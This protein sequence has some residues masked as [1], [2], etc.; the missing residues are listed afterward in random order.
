MCNIPFILTLTSFEASLN[1][2]I[3]VGLSHSKCAF[4]L[5]NIFQGQYNL[6][7]CFWSNYLLEVC[8]LFHIGLKHSSH[9]H[10]YQSPVTDEVD[11]PGQIP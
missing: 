4:M 3:H 6:F 7:K 1:E 10:C 8:H 9:I 2:G 11:Q 5:R